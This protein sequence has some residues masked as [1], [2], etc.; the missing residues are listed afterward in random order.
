MILKQSDSDVGQRQESTVASSS[1]SRD[2][3]CFT[4]VPKDVKAL[5]P[6]IGMFIDK[7]GHRAMLFALADDVQ[8]PP[9]GVSAEWRSKAREMALSL[10]EHEM[11]RKEKIEEL[12][13]HMDNEMSKVESL[14]WAKEDEDV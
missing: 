11:R 7:V 1:P 14:I 5:E 8:N 9:K 4:E 10:H 2:A 12:L 6:V 13:R 3:E